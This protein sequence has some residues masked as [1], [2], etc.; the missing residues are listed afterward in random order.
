[1]A[2]RSAKTGKDRMRMRRSDAAIGRR[3]NASGV[4]GRPAQASSSRRSASAL[5]PSTCSTS[6]AFSSP[7]DALIGA[8]IVAAD[9]ARRRRRRRQAVIGAAAGL[10]MDLDRNVHPRL[11]RS[12]RPIGRMAERRRATMWTGLSPCVRPLCRLTIFHGDGFGWHKPFGSSCSAR[13]AARR[14]T[15]SR[16]ALLNSELGRA[17]SPSG[18]LRL[19][20]LPHLRL[21]GASLGGGTRTSA[22]CP[23]TMPREPAAS[24]LRPPAGAELQPVVR[25]RARRPRDLVVPASDDACVADRRRRARREPL[26]QRRRPQA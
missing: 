6:A 15:R 17:A 10:A 13:T 3:V 14:S 7:S 4:R 19:P 26:A 22:D 2:S 24:R 9:R 8:A 11:H 21:A 25:T 5:W 1:M 20:A 16:D 12:I 23:A 18:R